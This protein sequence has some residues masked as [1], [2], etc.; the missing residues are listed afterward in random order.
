MKICF[1][2]ENLD[3]KAGI[4]RFGL[5]IIENISKDKNFDIFMLTKK[6]CGD[7]LEKPI[8]KKTNLLRN[9]INSSTNDKNI[10]K[11]QS[12]RTAFFIFSL[13]LQ[14]SAEVRGCRSIKECHY[15]P[16]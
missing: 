2:N 12:L 3:V 15:F 9:F 5:D 7:K 8:L 13:N 14:R 11:K 1:L 4:G 6:N 10:I 16:N